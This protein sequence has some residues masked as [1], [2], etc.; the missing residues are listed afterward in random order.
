MQLLSPIYHLPPHVSCQSNNQF[1]GR[2]ITTEG[3]GVGGGG[4]G[5][6]GGGREKKNARQTCFTLGHKVSKTSR[7]HHS[8]FLEL[9]HMAPTDFTLLYS[10]LLTLN[11]HYLIKA[12]Y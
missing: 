12:E 5:G 9:N 2:L 6:G 3:G 4:G 1:H 7:H 8:C 10:T 11:F